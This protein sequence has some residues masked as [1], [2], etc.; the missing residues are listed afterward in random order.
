M[1]SGSQTQLIIKI[2]GEVFLKTHSLDSTFRAVLLKLDVQMN[3]WRILLK[4]RF[5]FSSSQ[6]RRKKWQPT[7]SQVITL[8]V[9]I[10]HNFL[11]SSYGLGP[12]VKI[13][14]FVNL[15]HNQVWMPYFLINAVLLLIVIMSRDVLSIWVVFSYAFFQ[16]QFF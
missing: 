8:W 2:T 3:H 4:Y 11:F 10:P 12:I 9:V 13:P 15:P 7:S 6:M 14:L 16:A 1:D 5:W